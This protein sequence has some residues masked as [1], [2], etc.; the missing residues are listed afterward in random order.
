ML[1]NIIAGTFSAGVSP[2]T[3]SYESI[4]TVTVGSGGS[5]AIDFTSIPSTYKHLQ[6]R[7]ITNVSFASNTLGDIRLRVGNGSIDT[8]SNYA[9]HFLR[10]EGS[11]TPAADGFASSAFIATSTTRLANTDTSTF[12]AVVIDILD[13][14]ST[15]KNKTVRCLGGV[16][17][18]GSGYMNLNSGLWINSSNAITHLRL[19]SNDGN[20]NQYSQFALYG[21]RG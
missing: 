18:N 11:G 15:S 19:Y 14:A 5:S 4:A 3:N 8:G 2:V 17:A 21:I 10:G 16:D 12:G 7:G 20:L 6:I 1:G 9:R 13:Y